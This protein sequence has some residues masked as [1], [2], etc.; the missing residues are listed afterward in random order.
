[1][2]GVRR[3]GSGVSVGMVFL[4][5]VLVDDTPMQNAVNP[6]NHEISEEEEHQDALEEIRPA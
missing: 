2:E 6:I 4:V 5:D 1:M 3:E